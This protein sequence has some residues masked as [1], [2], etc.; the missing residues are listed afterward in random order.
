[1]FSKPVDILTVGGAT[2]DIMLTTSEYDVID[3]PDDITRKKLIAFEYGAKLVSDSTQISYGGGA[4]NSAVNFV[5]MG[6]S[7]ATK[8]QLGK[9]L[10]G[11]DIKRFLDSKGINV[12]HI[13]QKKDT[14]T[15]VSVI[16]SANKLHE[17][18]AFINRGANLLLDVKKSEL[19]ILEP[20]CLYLTSLSGDNAYNNIV[21]V[22]DY[23]RESGAKLVWNPGGRQIKWGCEELKTFLE[24]TDIL[25][26]NKDEAI[27]MI[28]STGVETDDVEELLKELHK[29]GPKVVTITCGEEGAW[30]YDG[31]KNYF[32][33]A[34]DVKKVNTTGA[35]DAFGST[36]TAAYIK[37]DGDIDYALAAGIVSSSK[38][39]GEKT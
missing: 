11:N 24:A 10:T 4:A 7:V 25:H 32:Q 33:K 8:I 22:F 14:L 31:S 18:V 3:N 15:A 29:M 6:F 20:K 2:L 17:H 30:A 37:K 36:F 38:V 19:R 16:V 28:C 13:V 12:K 23:V 35:G 26:I 5:Q 34:L 1:M 9:D 39:I 27:E 21:K